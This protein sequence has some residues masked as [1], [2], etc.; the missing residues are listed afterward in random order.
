MISRLRDIVICKPGKGYD[1]K[2]TASQLRRIIKEEVSRVTVEARKTA[3][4]KTAK[5]EKPNALQ[6]RRFKEYFEIDLKKYTP[7]LSRQDVSPD[8][9]QYFY[10][11]HTGELFIAYEGKLWPYEWMG[12]ESEGEWQ[13]ADDVDGYASDNSAGYESEGFEVTATIRMLRDALTRSQDPKVAMILQNALT[14]IEQL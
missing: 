4:P 11:D 13:E 3:K 2:L 7:V 5:P 9:D 1:M 14:K 10:D 12:G 8:E 6:M